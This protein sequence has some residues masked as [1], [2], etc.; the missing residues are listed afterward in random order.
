LHLPTG[1]TNYN[2]FFQVTVRTT[3]HEMFVTMATLYHISQK[4]NWVHQK[5]NQ[6]CIDNELGLA[7]KKHIEQP[8]ISFREV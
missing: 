8:S 1:I 2:F 7:R 6:D 3:I 4:Y 5:P